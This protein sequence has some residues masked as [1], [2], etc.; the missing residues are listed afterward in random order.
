[1]QITQIGR[2]G[3]WAILVQ[4]WPSYDTTGPWWDVRVKHD[5]AKGAYWLNWNGHRLARSRAL[6]NIESRNP[7][8]IGEVHE[9]LKTWYTQQAAIED[10]VG[11]A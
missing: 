2:I 7:G 6:S 11:I 5:D 4:P 8:L 1:M 9:T 10:A 3:P